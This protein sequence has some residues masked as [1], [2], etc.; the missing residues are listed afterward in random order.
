MSPLWSFLLHLFLVAATATEP[1][2]AAAGALPGCPDRCGNITVPY[3]FGIATGCYRRGFR[4]ACNS[5][6]S[7]PKL[8][9]SKN[10]AVSEI[11]DADLVVEAPIA[12]NCYKPFNLGPDVELTTVDVTGTP[13]T[14]SYS[15]NK[16]T[17]LGCDTVA[18]NFQGGNM[19]DFSSGCVSFCIDPSSINNGTCDGIG[20]CQTSIPR[21]L[22]QLSTILRSLSNHTGTFNF[23]PCSYA[24]LVE[25]DSFAFQLT[26]LYSFAR[27]STVPVVLDWAIG[28]QPCDVAAQSWNYACGPNSYCFNA[29]NGG[30]YGC[31]CNSGYQGNPYLPNGCQDIDEC[32][33]PSTNTCSHICTNYPG[34]YACSCPRGTTGDGRK[35]GTGCID[36][37]KCRPRLRVLNRD[38]FMGYWALKKRRMILLRENFFK[39]NGGLMLQ[40]RISS[41]GSAGERARIFSA[42]ELERATDNYSESRI[43]GKGGYGTV[44]KGILP[45]KKVVAIKKSKVVD[46]TQVEQFIN[47]VVV[48][49]E[50]IHRNVVKILG[51]CLETQVPLLV[52]EYVPNGTL[53]HH[54]HG[55]DHVSTVSWEIRLRIAAETAGALAYLHSA[56]TWPIVHRDVKTANILL[57][58]DYTA[59]VTTLVQGTMGYLDPEYFQTGLLTE[60]S[61]VYSFGVVLAE[62][63]TGQKPLSQTRPEEEQNLAIYFLHAVR[64]KQ[65]LNILEPRIRKEASEEQ[66]E[67]VARVTERCLSLR[68][69]ERPTM[70]EV[71][72]ELER[73]R[74]PR[75]TLGPHRLRTVQRPLHARRREAASRR[76]RTYLGKTIRRP[77]VPHRLSEK[78]SIVVSSSNVPW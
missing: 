9:L 64:R 58:D 44:Y 13:Y 10:M 20:C 56:T 73:L 36:S 59:K 60:K 33:D 65:L 78:H 14:L 18:L 47:E 52:Y 35:L 38:L 32:A 42:E 27:K 51:C 19:F 45:D 28:S 46:E 54:L 22:Q 7:P 4:M 5:S 12:R 53:T 2:E 37:R 55:D 50:V 30:G 17:A 49:S 74:L 62:L 23:S 41:L 48:L 11:R 76:M 69:E 40:Q 70:K 31:R 63:L 43:L 21:G 29:T 72:V 71:A 75:R 68:G 66:L 39:Q 25:Q 3:P 15:R 6:Y 26:D 77:T 24:F 8:F 57:D 16:F 34:D 1:A 67:M 61:D